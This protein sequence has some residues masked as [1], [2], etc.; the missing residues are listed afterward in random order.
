[1]GFFRRVWP[2]D[3]LADKAAFTFTHVGLIAMCFFELLVVL[4]I[5]HENFS[6]MFYV[7]F[8]AG[9]FILIQV[10]SN[11]YK[12]I[13]TDST[14]NSPKFHLPSVLMPEWR[15]CS[16]CQVNI[17][18]RAHHCKICDVCVIKRDH[19]C[20]FTGKCIGLSNHRYFFVFVSYLWIGCFYTI[21]FNRE[22]YLDILGGY[23]FGL[24]FQLFCPMLAWLLGYAN[25]HQLLIL[26]V[27]G[28]NMMAMF[29]FSC[30]MAF[31]IAFISRGQTQFECKKKIRDYN[32]GF[33]ENWR[34]VLGK[35]WY[36]TWLCYSIPS[37]L[38]VTGTNFKK[39]LQRDH[40]LKTL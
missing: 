9:I 6:T 11:M 2:K 19:H 37:E 39:C 4:P 38:P 21:Y 3:N 16:I 23:R 35:N 28:V 32:K 7:H 31:Q 25:S 1:M 36:L 27:S 24:I 26:L 18:L 34:T 40:G 5:Y 20:I 14:V 8:G 15:Y 17:P 13:F 30:L 12:S 33:Y 10:F 29:L 22:Y